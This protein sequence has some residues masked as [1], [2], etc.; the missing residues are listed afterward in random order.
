MEQ[1]NSELVNLNVPLQVAQGIKLC[2]S[3]LVLHICC[4]CD[5]VNLDAC[6]K[7]LFHLIICDFQDIMMYSTYCNITMQV[8][9]SF[10]VS[11]CFDIC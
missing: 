1:I 8:I 3:S 7:Y 9:S 2:P 5:E 11:K 4:S 6:W 10:A